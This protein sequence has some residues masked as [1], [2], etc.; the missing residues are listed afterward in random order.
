[1]GTIKKKA[2]L[3]CIYLF[4]WLIDWLIDLGNQMFIQYL[5]PTLFLVFKIYLVI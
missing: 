1:M 5:F 3:I 4:D 2:F